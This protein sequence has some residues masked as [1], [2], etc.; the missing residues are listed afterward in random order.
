[1]GLILGFVA[2]ALVFAIAAVVVGREARRLAAKAPGRVFEFEDAVNWVCDHVG[3]EVAAVLSPDDVRR[4]LNWHLEYFRIKGV[5]SNGASP[6]VEGPVVVSGAETVDF[7][8]KRAEAD[9]L[10]YTP[11]QVHAVLD[12]QMTYLESIG[13]VGPVS[14]RDE[15]PDG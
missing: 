7:V 10:D 2:I 15:G 11:S 14:D 12:A 3:E 1:M 6:N 4:I 5:S 9:G 13:A 8:L